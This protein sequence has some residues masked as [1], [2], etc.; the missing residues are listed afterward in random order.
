[1][2]TCQGREV[3][4]SRPSTPTSREP[5]VTAR[6]SGSSVRRRRGTH[7]RGRPGS[8][9]RS[10][11]TAAE[12]D[13]AVDEDEGFVGD[14]EGQVRRA[15]RRARR[16]RRCRRRCAARREAGARRPTVRVPC[17]S[18]RPGGPSA[19]APARGP[20][21]ASAARRPTTRRHGASSADASAGNSSS[22]SSVGSRPA[23]RTPRGGC[24]ARSA[25]GTARG[26]RVRGRGLLVT[27]QRPRPLLSSWPAT[28]TVPLWRG[29]SPHIVES[30]VVLPAPFGPR[31]ATTVPASAERSNGR[32]MLTCPYP[33]M[34]SRHSKSGAAGEAGA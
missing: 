24:R 17:S 2:T 14:F 12:R 19:A 3:G 8:R 26:R 31:M 11:R 7:P 27:P 1:M 15:A 16:P 28:C 6:A 21:R 23:L 22:I 32:T 25:T 29:S 30:S 33:A 20:S 34:R 9:W 18:R 5:A 10:R 4:G 13:L